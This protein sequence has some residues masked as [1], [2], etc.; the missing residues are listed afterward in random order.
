LENENDLLKEELE[1]EKRIS[2]SA[3]ESRQRAV[4]ELDPLHWRVKELEREQR[5]KR[6]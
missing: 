1:R 6:L 5:G 4:D 2:Q 3:V